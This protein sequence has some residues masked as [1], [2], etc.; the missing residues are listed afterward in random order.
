[1]SVGGV[2]SP[3][4]SFSPCCGFSSL[5]H[6]EGA[7]RIPRRPLNTAEPEAGVG[8][9]SRAGTVLVKPCCAHIPPGGLVHTRILP[10][11]VCCGA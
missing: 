11:E 1:M 2:N 8:T 5:E 9:R 4:G 3:G 7:K 6:P 10:R